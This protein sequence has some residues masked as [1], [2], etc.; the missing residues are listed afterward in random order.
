[1]LTVMCTNKYL[2]TVMC[3]NKYLF[4]VEKQFILTTL[5]SYLSH[6]QI[7]FLFLCHILHV[8]LSMGSP[9]LI[10]LNLV[11]EIWMPVLESA[12]QIQVSA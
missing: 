10:N 11:V 2:L 1:M 7:V 5:T 9:L 8:I 6:Q 12:I 3:T 4:K